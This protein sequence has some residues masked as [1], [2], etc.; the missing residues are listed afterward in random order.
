MGKG[1]ADMQK[2]IHKTC[3][4][5]NKHQDIYKAKTK[6]CFRF[7]DKNVIYLMIENDNLK[8]AILY[9]YFWQ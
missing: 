7:Q 1:Q 3:D 9:D 5:T 4:N 6:Y 2:N 8:Y